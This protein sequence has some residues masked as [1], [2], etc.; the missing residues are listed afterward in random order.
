VTKVNIFLASCVFILLLSSG[1]EA[2]K[3]LAVTTRESL[4]S[5]H[6]PKAT[7][8]A[9]KRSNSDVWAIIKSAPTST[10]FPDAAADTVLDASDVTIS[11]DGTIV[12]KDHEMLRIF[13]DRAHDDG[14]IS[15]PYSSTTDSLSNLSARTILANGKVIALNPGDVHIT[16][17]FSGYAMYDD[18]KIA[19]FSMPGIQNG[20]II[21]YSYTITSKPILPHDFSETW[22]FSDGNYPVKIS[23][24]RVTAPSDL[25]ISSQILN[26]PTLTPV[27]TTHGSWTTYEWAMTNLSDIDREPMMPPDRYIFPLIQVSS[28]QSWQNISQWYW[29]LAKNEEVI[30]PDLHQL[31]LQQIAGKTTDE[32]KAKALFYWVE[33]NIRYVAVELGQSAWQP[34]PPEQVYVNRYGDCKD[35]ATLLV[36]MLR[37]AGIK[38]AY[39][40]LLQAESDIPIEPTLPSTEAFDHCI[41]RATIDGKDYWFDCTAEICGFGDIPGGDRG[42]NVLV[43]KDDG[44]GEFDTIPRFEPRENSLHIDENVTL[45][46]DGSAT[47]VNEM[48]A[49][50]DGDLGLR[51][52]F[53]QIKPNLVQDGVRNL[54]LRQNP[55]ATLLTY[56]LSDIND[57]DSPFSLSYT[58]TS[59]DFAQKTA[60]LLLFTP[61]PFGGSIGSLTKPSRTYPIYTDDISSVL[62]S[63]SIQIPDGYTVEDVPDNMDQQLPFA[64]YTRTI[65]QDGQTLKVFFDISM[66]PSLTPADQYSAVQ[67][68][69]AKLRQ[70]ISEPVVLRKQLH[71]DGANNPAAAL[72]N[73]SK[74]P[75]WKAL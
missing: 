48:V 68:E 42:A 22:L 7:F 75:T 61:A 5:T 3:K 17:P 49:H 38:D 67:Q 73:F 54:A 57:R 52:T 19:S 31:V 1:A 4:P 12:E 8:S 10:Q 74:T 46:E 72:Y 56:K 33:E 30:T 53:R 25:K 63:Y 43:V 39:P 16:S 70:T 47:C 40:V 34:H 37:D 51:S 66:K 20:A 24:F 64:E 50:G 60:N 62:T 23:R 58:F 11:P 55:D 28:L 59:P 27:I 35:M 13:N 15:I 2:A 6:A 65:E 41:A 26:S 9:T 32:D 36:T 71:D 29:K 14:N 18:S 44:S 45:S 69:L 21:D